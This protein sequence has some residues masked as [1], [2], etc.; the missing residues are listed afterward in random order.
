MIDP[1]STIAKDI[2]AYADVARHLILFG[3]DHG[4][5]TAI[6]Q[7]TRRMMKTEAVLSAKS[8]AVEAWESPQN[9][10]HLGRMIDELQAACMASEMSPMAR[11]LGVQ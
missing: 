2:A 10:N 3:D 8:K 9:F 5:K 4:Y 7:M 11:A 6:A 1:S